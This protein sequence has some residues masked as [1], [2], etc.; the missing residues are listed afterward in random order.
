MIAQKIN[1]LKKSNF[2]MKTIYEIK[3]V[4]TFV[5]LLICIS[6][7]SQEK[8]EIEF[9]PAYVVVTKMHWNSDGNINFEEWIKTEEE[10]FN[11]VTDKNEL[12]LHSGVYTHFLTS[13]S[14]EILFLSVYD[15]WRDFEDAME[16]NEELIEEGW[17]N[18]EDRNAFFEKQNSFYDGKHSD[19]MFS[20]LPY[21]KSI[22]SEAEDPLI[23]YVRKSKGKKGG[24]GY[25][26]YFEN[27][28][29]KNQYIKGYFTMKHVFGSD[30]RDALEIGFFESL[31]DIESSF[32]ENR[33]LAEAHWPDEEKRKEFFVEFNKIFGIHGD[34]IY[35]NVPELA[36]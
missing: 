36:K 32:E 1:P 26:E 35:K 21:K 18:E 24:S 3:L 27:V 20:T 15:S 22:E 5:I 6:T 25:A 19:E 10:Y 29:L 8:S 33:K 7:Y 28:I 17:S 30:N 23:I 31:G 9:E 34:F 14:S 13:D 16:I 4:L 11:K 12:V 2:T